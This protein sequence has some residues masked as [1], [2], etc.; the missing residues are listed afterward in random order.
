MYSN[1]FFNDDEINSDEIDP[2]CFNVESDFVE[3]LSNRDTLIDSSVKF[4]FLE[5]FSGALMPTS[6]ADEERITREHAEYISL[7]ERLITI[8]PCPRPMVNANTIVESL[9][10]SL[11]PIQ[12]IDSQREEID[13]VTDTDELLPPG[14]ENDD[15]EE[16]IHFLKNYLSMIPFP[17]LTMSH[18]IL[19]LIRY[20][21]D[22]LRNHRMLSFYLIR[23]PMIYPSMIEVYCV[24]FYC[25][26]P[27]ELHILSLRLVWGNPYP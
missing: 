11:I 23:S 16:E 22:L 15:S 1:P 7:L 24:R 14:F 27:Q 8:N 18:L 19:R 20:F 13:I 10:S 21:L 9:P 25:P 5:E 3:S 12:D 26:G 6:V 17:F 4:D 2:H